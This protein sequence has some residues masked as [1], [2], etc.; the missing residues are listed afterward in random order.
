VNKTD[1]AKDFLH[2]LMLEDPNELLVDLALEVLEFGNTN[3]TDAESALKTEFAKYVT[4][5]ESAKWDV[6]D[7]MDTNDKLMDAPWDL[8]RTRFEREA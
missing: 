6:D 4:A 3:L 2:D 1:L 8:N 5:K 7:V